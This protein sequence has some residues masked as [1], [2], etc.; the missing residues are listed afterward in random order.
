MLAG[1]VSR[2][3]AEKATFSL[4]GLVSR[5]VTYFDKISI[6]ERSSDGAIADKSPGAYRVSSDYVRRYFSIIDPPRIVSFIS[7]TRHHNI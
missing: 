7:L 2:L 1:N 5:N 3:F 4:D 6:L